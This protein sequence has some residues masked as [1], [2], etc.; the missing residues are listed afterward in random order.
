MVEGFRWLPLLHHWYLTLCPSCLSHQDRLS[1]SFISP[2]LS[3]LF[4]GYVW[5]HVDMVEGFRGLS[6]LHHWYLTSCPSYLLHQE[7]LFYSFMLMATVPSLSIVNFNII[8]LRAV[9]LLGGWT[10]WALKVL[11]HSTPD[12]GYDSKCLPNSRLSLYWILHEDWQGYMT[13]L[14]LIIHYW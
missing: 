6:L 14:P 9:M 1:C 10:D 2:D 8:S 13:L 7:R 3:E 11:L 12:S 4:L 5:V